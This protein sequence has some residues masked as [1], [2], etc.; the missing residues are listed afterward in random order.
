VLLAGLN[1][2]QNRTGS[3]SP[4]TYLTQAY[5]LK[6]LQDVTLRTQL[7]W[8]R[9]LVTHASQ[10]L[11]AELL[12]DQWLDTLVATT[13]QKK[14]KAQKKAYK[15]INEQRVSVTTSTDGLIYLP[16]RI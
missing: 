15:V 8:L 16:S 9:E 7:D 10:Q 11:L 1:Q 6:L 5:P 3:S 13:A 2:Q 4:M 12:S 14:K